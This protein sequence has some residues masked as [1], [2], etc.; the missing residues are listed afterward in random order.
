MEGGVDSESVGSG[1]V[2]CLDDGN[3]CVGLCIKVGTVYWEGVGMT[4]LQVD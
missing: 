3:E 4:L 1:R 2:V